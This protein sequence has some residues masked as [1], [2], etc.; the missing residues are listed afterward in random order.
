MDGTEALEGAGCVRGSD[1]G[2]ELVCIL[3]SPSMRFLASLLEENSR[4]SVAAASLAE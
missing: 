2:S 1:N 4:V 3:E